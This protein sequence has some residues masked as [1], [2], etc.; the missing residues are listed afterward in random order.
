MR[1]AFLLFVSLISPLTCG[2]A[3][4]SR[5]PITVHVLDTNRGKP[6]A[7]MPV[8]LEQAEGKEWREIGK[9]KTGADGRIENLLP[10]DKRFVAG[11]YR[12]TFDTGAYFADNKMKTFYPQVVITFAVEKPTEHYH[13]PL[14]LSPFGYSTYRGN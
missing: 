10:K 6:A 11:V 8:V 4:P 12:V 2:A 5:S 9:A 14:I 3:E 13:V 1:A 7:D